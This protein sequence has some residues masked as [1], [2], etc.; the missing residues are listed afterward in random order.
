MLFTYDF[1]LIQTCGRATCD[2]EEGLL[3]E[4]HWTGTGGEKTRFNWCTRKVGLQHSFFLRPSF[5]VHVN[6]GLC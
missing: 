4:E 6:A 1:S 3:G 5:E 2:A